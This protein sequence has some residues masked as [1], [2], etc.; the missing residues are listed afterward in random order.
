MGVWFDSIMLPS[1]IS[2]VVGLCR[3]VT[4]ILAEL[5]IG[6]VYDVMNDSL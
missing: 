5:T 3:A 4:Q 2:V 1:F 6:K